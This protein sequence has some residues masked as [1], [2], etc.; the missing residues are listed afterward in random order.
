V[1]ETNFIKAKGKTLISRIDTK[2]L[3]TIEYGSWVLAWIV[4][5]RCVFERESFYTKIRRDSYNS[6]F[7]LSRLL[8]LSLSRH[9]GY[10][11]LVSWKILITASG[12]GHAGEQAQAL[13]RQAGCQLV[14]PPKLGPLRAAELFPLLKGI[15]A[16]IASLDEFSAPVL[17]SQNGARLKIIARW[18]VG[19]DSV[20]LVAATR[21]GIV[22]TYTPG[23][24]DEAV[25][26]YTLAL[27]LAMSRRVHEGY[28]AMRNTQWK[29]AWGHDL[30]GKTLGIVGCGRIGLAVARRAV[31]FNLRLIGYDPHPSAQARRLGIRLVTL[32]HLL[33]RSDFVSLHAALTE[34]SRRLIGKAELSKMKPTAC[35]INTARGALVDEAA[36]AAALS[37]KQIAGAAL[38]VF[39]TEPLPAT[40]PLRSAPNLLLSPHQASFSFE[41]GERVSTAAAQA[42]LAVMRGKRP[43][44]VLNPDVFKSAEFKAKAKSK[45]PR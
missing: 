23:L 7:A 37:K 4:A 39:A 28:T 8:A 18:G 44:N 19:F 32:E 34:R 27:L 9:H 1:L 14:F 40:N 31:G 2:F 21:S 29:V 6:F 13:L 38:D 11:P 16:V 15:D 25:A 20:D 41:T 43:K 12:V 45:R 36:L 5:E 33:A 26:E 17:S 22:V 3:I 42:V 24:L 30:A 35:L 10:N